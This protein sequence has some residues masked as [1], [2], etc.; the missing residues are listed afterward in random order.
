[1]LP[2]A[3]LT[4]HS[5]ISDC[6]WVITPSLLSGSLRSFLYSSS[7]FLPLLLNIFCFCYVHTLS[8]LYCTYLWMKCSLGISHFLTRSPFFPILLFSCISL[9]CSLK[10]ALLSLLAI[11]WNFACSWHIFPIH[12]WLSL[13]FFSQIFV[14]PPQTTI[15]TS[16]IS[17]S[18][19]CQWWRTSI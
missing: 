8:V 14:R 1:M 18:L 10:K 3:R 19:G 4:L 5:R 13:L 16:C 2:K 15:L 6:K 9:H 17:F 12:L 7:L 11:L